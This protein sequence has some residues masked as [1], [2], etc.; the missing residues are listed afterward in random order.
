[1]HWLRTGRSYL[2]GGDAAPLL[3]TAARNAFFDL[4]NLE[5]TNENEFKTLQNVKMAGMLMELFW[6]PRVA[7]MADGIEDGLKH[8]AAMGFTGLVPTL[9]VIPSMTLT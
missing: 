1:M 2:G 4:F 5:H 6:R 3:N 7:M 8:Y 9:S